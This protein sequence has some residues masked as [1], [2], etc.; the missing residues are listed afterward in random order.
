MYVLIKLFL[1]LLHTF[2]EEVL[3]DV[4]C[5]VMVEELVVELLRVLVFPNG[6]FIIIIGSY[7]V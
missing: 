6:I 4:T 5:K 1:I 7:L 3:S 2:F